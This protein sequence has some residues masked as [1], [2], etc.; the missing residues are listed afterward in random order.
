V[1]EAA[2]GLKPL[3][4]GINIQPHAVR[5]L[6]ELGLGDRMPAVGVAT[7][8]FAMFNKHGQLI[9]SEPRGRAAGYGW[10]QYSVHRGRFTMMLYEAAVERLGQARIKLDHELIG[11]EQDADGV[12]AHFADRDGRQVA[13]ERGDVMLAADGIH[14]GVRQHFY[15]DQGEPHFSGEMMWR[16]AVIGRPFLDGRTHAIAGHQGRRFLA[17]PIEEL[18]DGRVLINWIC[19]LGHDGTTP[20]R[21]DWN[22]QVPKEMFAGSFA[23]WHFPWLDVPALIEA[24]E[25]YFEFPKVDRDPIPRWTFDRV[26]LIG[27]AAHPMLPTGSQAGSQAV[28]DARYVVRALLLEATPQAALKRFEDERLKPMNEI[29][30]RNRRHGP[31][32]AMQIA[33]ERAPDGFERIEDVIPPE[34]MRELSDSFKRLAG[35]EKDQLNSRPSLLLDLIG[36]GR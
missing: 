13:A 15:P 34:E 8:T 27:D 26:T 3:G 23:D 30:L 28:V 31:E 25:T 16:A 11:F 2:P 12:T 29:T 4:V 7:Q 36:S 19:E 24:T 35:F 1:L 21:A 14:S 20:P 32:I 6:T 9:W 5:E 22:K 18:A 17:Y 33:E 10:P